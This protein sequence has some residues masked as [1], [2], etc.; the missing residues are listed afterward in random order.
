MVAIG[1]GIVEETSYMPM[2]VTS[3]VG[4]IQNV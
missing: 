4:Y 1:Q 3:P 2:N